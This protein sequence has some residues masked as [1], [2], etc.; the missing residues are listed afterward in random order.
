MPSGGQ[1]SPIAL[2]IINENSSHALLLQNTNNIFEG[3]SVFKVL[4]ASSIKHYGLII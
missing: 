3:Q 4:E 2:S 1:Y